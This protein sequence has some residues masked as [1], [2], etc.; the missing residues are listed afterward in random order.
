MPLASPLEPTS[1][2]QQTASNVRS[3]LWEKV[4]IIREKKELNT[5]V[6]QLEAISFKPA[7]NGRDELETQNILQVARVIARSALARQ[8]SRGAHYCSDFPLAN[9]AAP[10]RH[11]YLAANRPVYFE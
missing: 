2:A 1:D 6:A 9:D 7:Q 11:S 8:E 5:A 3:L 4:G 10:P